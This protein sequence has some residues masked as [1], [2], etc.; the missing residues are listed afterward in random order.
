MGW[1]SGTDIAIAVVTAVKANVSDAKVRLKIYKPFLE[2]MEDSDWDTQDEA[3]DIDPVFDK[4]I[5][6]TD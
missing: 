4:L 3:M 2:A 6:N 5:S 1:S